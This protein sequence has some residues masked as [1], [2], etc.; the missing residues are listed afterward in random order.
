MPIFIFSLVQ[1]IM[2][3]PLLGN[4]AEVCTRHSLGEISKSLA[5]LMTFFESMGFFFV[6]A[7]QLKN[8]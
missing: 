6:T 4:E 1:I 3:H 7:K 5:N 2:G 8:N